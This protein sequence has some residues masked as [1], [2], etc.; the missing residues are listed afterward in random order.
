MSDFVAVIGGNVAG[1]R[2]SAVAHACTSR[3]SAPVAVKWPLIASTFRGGMPA[4]SRAARTQ[5][6]TPS[7][8]GAVMLPP[9]RCPPQFTAPPSTSARI[10]APRSSALSRLS[11]RSTPAPAAGTKPAAEALIGREARSGASFDARVRT[12]IASNPAQV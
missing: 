7:G 3:G 11:S 12:R 6:R 1:D 10:G 8:L 9:A 5:R 4:S 2:S